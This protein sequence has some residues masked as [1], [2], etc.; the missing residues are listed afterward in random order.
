MNLTD[1]HSPLEDWLYLE[2]YVNIGSD[3]KF[4]LEL[5]IPRQF[6]P[7][8]DTVDFHLYQIDN[9]EYSRMGKVS[10]DYF[11][12]HPA[13]NS[14][15][16]SQG[17]S[18]TETSA[19]YA[20]SSS[21]RTLFSR[22]GK[23]FVK[24]DLP[25][26]IGRFNRRLVKSDVIFSQQIDAT[27]TQIREQAKPHGI[28]FGIL[29]EIGGGFFTDTTGREPAFIEREM[30]PYWITKPDKPASRLFM[31]PL[32]SLPAQD[33]KGKCKPL[34]IQIIDKHNKNPI[35]FILQSIIIPLIDAWHTL[36]KYGILW[37]MQSQNT[38]FALDANYLPHGVVIRDNDA[39]YINSFLSSPTDPP[40]RDSYIK[41]VIGLR[42]ESIERTSLSFDHRLCKQSI[43]QLV[44]CFATHYGES[45]AD[46]L[47]KLITEY[48]DSS[49]NEAIVANLPKNKWY[50]HPP[51][52]FHGNKPLTTA[53]PIP[54]FRTIGSA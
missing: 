27:I 6:H 48:V 42:G 24:V 53:I 15:Y 47:S 8:S 40:L 44:T 41:H 2:R 14:L 43:Q 12:I 46:E 20:P 36:A 45:S 11:P 7:L 38:L 35:Q 31:V 21:A 18:T 37:E 17:Y 51:I 33:P 32:F 4:W 13:I 23:G 22:D 1:L 34:L 30:T 3:H 52:M 49:L 9:L 16:L 19:K 28:G 25:L 29:R 26:K 10:T 54:L 39:A 5:D 50:T